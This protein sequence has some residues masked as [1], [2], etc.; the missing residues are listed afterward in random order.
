MYQ[1]EYHGCTSP[2]VDG[3]L[4]CI[5]HHR[6]EAKLA[7]RLT[8]IGGVV[9]LVVTAVVLAG[10]ILGACII[11]ELLRPRRPL[12]ICHKRS[13][14][15]EGEAAADSEQAEE[16]LA[17]MLLKDTAGGQKRRSGKEA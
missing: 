5:R 14:Q 15:H 10:A 11:V 12:Y 3:T 17:G 9:M 7:E 2:A 16:R 4:L 13:C 1:C 6:Q 8:A